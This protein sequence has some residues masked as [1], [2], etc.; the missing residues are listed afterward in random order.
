M[1]RSE[2]SLLWAVDSSLSKGMCALLQVVKRAIYWLL[3][4]ITLG[5][6]PLMIVEHNEG[7]ADISV[8]EWGFILLIGLLAWRHI[9]YCRHF[10]IGFWAGASRLLMAQGLM[11]VFQLV[12]LGCYAVFMVY[13]NQLQLLSEHL[14]SETLTDKIL[15]LGLI[16]IAMYLGAPTSGGTQAVADTIPQAHQPA[17]TPSAQAAPEAV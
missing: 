6:L 1:Q 5:A 14:L 2:L 13:S 3:G 7:V 15:T 11:W 8:M 17:A 16:A 9:R 12:C 4:L 10:S